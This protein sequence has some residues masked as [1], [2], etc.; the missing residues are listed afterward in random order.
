M[1]GGST[2]IVRVLLDSGCEVARNEEALLIACTQGNA[3]I[4]RLLLE[5]GAPMD[6]L[7]QAKMCPLRVA[8]ERGEVEIVRLMLRAGARAEGAHEERTRLDPLLGI[9]GL[10]RGCRESA[11][12]GAVGGARGDSS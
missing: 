3:E 1:S 12:V 2:E 5:H 7:N 8:S 11:R 6:S 9:V 10:A 4:V